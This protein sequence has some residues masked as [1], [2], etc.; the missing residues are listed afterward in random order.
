MAHMKNIVIVFFI[1]LIGVS[2]SAQHTFN[3]PYAEVRDVKGFHGVKVST[4][5]HLVLTQGSS[6]AVAVSAPNEEDRSRIKTIVEN[7]VL[8]IYY[9]YN[10]GK[11]IRGKISKKLKA[12][13]SIV[14]VNLLSASSGAI[15]ET[16][17]EI[18]A[19]DLSLRATSGAILKG[20][21]KAG[22]VDVDQSS[23]AIVQLSGAADD[24]D[25]HGSSGSVFQGYDLAVNAC[26]AA[27]SSGAVAQVTVNKEISGRA[28]SGGHISYKG[29]GAIK[30]KKTSSGGHVGKV[31]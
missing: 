24:L 13:V 17:G 11:L 29:E 27:T 18:K 6:E 20:T 16:E 23:G 5:I 31:R 21:I 1:L 26:N 2:V 14:N 12:Y 30:S 19:Q 22:S 4:G 7:G 15:L 9:D 10:M 28:S 3:D 8:K 25:V